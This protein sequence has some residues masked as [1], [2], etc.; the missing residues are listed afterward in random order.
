MRTLARYVLRQ[1]PG[2]VGA[3]FAITLFVSILEG[4]GVGLLIP[5]VEN[6]AAQGELTSTHWFSRQLGSI[7]MAVGIPFN[8]VTI[9]LVGLILFTGHQVLL[10][11][12]ARVVIETRTQVVLDLR[13]R[14]FAN[15]IHAEVG[16]LDRKN[17]GHLVNGVIV[18]SDRAGAAVTCLAEILTLAGVA[19]MYLIVA[20]FISWPLTLFAAALLGGLSLAV[21]AYTRRG[22]ETGRRI[23][24]A[25]NALQAVA[26]EYLG[27]VRVIR[28]F[29]SE[30]FS[31]R[32]FAERAREVGRLMAE[33][34]RANA[35]VGFVYEVTLFGALVLIVYLALTHLSLT[36]ALIVT[37]L[38]ILYRLSPRAVSINRYRHQLSAHLPGFMEVIRLIE[39]TSRPLVVSGNV[40]FR[41]LRQAIEFQHVSFGYDP[42]QM[43]L[44]DLSV[45]IEKGKTTVF[46]GASGVGKTTLL[47]LLLRLY[48]PS[49]GRI[50]VDGVDLR[51][52]D[53]MTWRRSIAVVSQE[54]FLFNDTIWNNILVGCP[55]ANEE[56]VMW[57]ARLAHVDKFVSLLPHGYESVIGDRG[58][59]LSGGQR[60]RLALARAFI[61][62]SQI[63][64]LDEPTSA[65]DA[66]SDVLLQES[67]AGLR[68][69]HTVIIVAHRL[70][71]IRRADKILVL[72]NGRVIE[73]GDH[74]SLLKH[75]QRYA[76]Y[77]QLQLGG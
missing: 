43:V 41:G 37:F 77:Y 65:L 50:L 8:L 10:Y 31:A 53:L 33:H 11:A 30:T 58:V 16:Y 59:R 24:E 29:G 44:R 64:I 39:E 72:E 74:E 22:G 23:T 12:R 75:G 61:R 2:L 60:Q 3:L 28:A 69:E 40:V 51:A 62:E 71:T 57:A 66:E 14:A 27:G 15:A 13:S 42:D 55:D 56:Q 54:T 19:V 7:F 63:L 25:N 46:V 6:V 70:S 32:R 68:G 35:Q 34:V 73:E 20:F 36:P 45:V 21:Q 49:E 38:F 26:M 47:D 48:D 9:L 76:K 67:L 4:M 5:I 18:E 1:H 52:F 17:P